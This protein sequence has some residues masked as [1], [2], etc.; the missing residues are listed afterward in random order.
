MCYAIPAKVIEIG[1]NHV[2][3]DYYGEKRKALKDL[4]DLKLGDYILVQGGVVVRKVE[5]EEA[6][7]TL[8]A[9]KELFF[10]L[11]KQDEEM[12]QEPGRDEVSEIK[13]RY[14]ATSKILDK[15]GAGETLTQEEELHLLRLN[16]RAER[17]MFY[18]IA[19]HLRNQRLHNSCCIHGII[20]FSNFCSEDC[21]Y[22]G[23]R[24]GSVGLER[25]RLSVKEILELVRYAVNDLGFGALVLQSGEDSFFTADKIEE[26]IKTI[27]ENFPCLVFLS[28]GARSAADYQRFYAAGA[29]GVLLRFESS[30]PEL[31]ASLRPGRKLE[32]RLTLLREIYKMGYLV[33]TGGLIGIP[34]QTESDLVNDLHLARELKAEMYSFGPFICPAD[35]PLN[36]QVQ[37]GQTDLMAKVLNTIAL[38]RVLDP[39]SKILVTTALET[40]APESGRREALL[41]GANSLMLN[42]TPPAYRGLYKIYPNRANLSIPIEEQIT[43]TLALLKDLGRAPTDLGVSHDRIY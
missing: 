36:N 20:E 25:Y 13:L 12:S 33:A 7:E 28:I 15:I 22:C 37:L 11:Q 30:N 35:S 23:I 18:R 3:V 40:L 19:N 32:D 17:Q 38:A 4:T 1:D 24:K 8:K 43:S 16:S 10:V 2:T 29:R 26:I 21:A 14:P 42:V 27:K 31:F 9:W 5:P 41:A 39:E 34:G 6:E